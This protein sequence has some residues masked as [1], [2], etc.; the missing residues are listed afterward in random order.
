MFLLT[1]H[2]KVWGESPYLY[3]ALIAL[4]SVSVMVLVIF[5]FFFFTLSKVLIQVEFEPPAAEAK[6]FGS[7]REQAF[8]VKQILAYWVDQ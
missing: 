2:E 3:Q 8:M 6:N 4:K 7:L 1:F 5:F